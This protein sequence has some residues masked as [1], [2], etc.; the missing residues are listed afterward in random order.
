MKLDLRSSLL[1]VYSNIIFRDF[2]KVNYKIYFSFLKL[3]V[4]MIHTAHRCLLD[5][6][7]FFCDSLVESIATSKI[8]GF[9]AISG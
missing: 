2:Q 6:R 3:L 1:L 5:K 7:L 9:I 4:S 8:V